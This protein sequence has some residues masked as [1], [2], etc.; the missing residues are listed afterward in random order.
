MAISPWPLTRITGNSAS[1]ARISLSHSVPVMPGSLTSLSTTAGTPARMRVR[2]SSTEAKLSTVSPASAS[3]CAL[4]M[5]TSASSATKITRIARASLIYLK[6]MY[7]CPRQFD[8][9][10]GAG[11]VHLTGPQAAAELAHDVRR[12]HQAQP[13][14]GAGRF[15]GDERFKQSRQDI[16]PNA[17]TG[18]ADPDQTVIQGRADCAGL[19]SQASQR[20]CHHGVN[21]VAQQIDQHLFQPCLFGQR[22]QTD[23]LH[24][25]HQ[26]H[27]VI[28]Q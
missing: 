1:M 24:L 16:G 14:T 17:G 22:R 3:A 7:F 12:D 9:K 20:R 13:Q 15:A 2:A 6:L 23:G 11:A 27:A 25:H 8:F 5:R 10:A 26:F 28:A 4:P 18:V 21:G 19:H